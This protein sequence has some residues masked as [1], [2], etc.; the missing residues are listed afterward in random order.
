MFRAWKPEYL[1]TE[2]VGQ[3]YHVVWFPKYRRRILNSGVR[4]YL[5]KLF[6]E[7]MR[8]LPGCEIIELNILMDHIHMLIVTPPK[9]GVS[10]VIRQMKTAY[11]KSIEGKV[12]WLEKV[13]WKKRVVWSSGY[14][15]STV[16]LDKKQI[17]AYV[18]WQA[19]Q[20]SGQAKLE[21]F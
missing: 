6:P 12:N 17:T 13:Y 4:G 18:K 10:A 5:R 1:V 9:Y 2:F 16:G 7:V 19:H 3:N 11:S 20:D 15:V 14:S 21:L 8:S